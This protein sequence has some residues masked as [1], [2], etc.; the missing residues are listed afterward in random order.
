MMLVLINSFL[1]SAAAVA[2][3]LA[4]SIV[5]RSAV[6]RLVLWY[7]ALIAVLVLSPLTLALP[8]AQG[9][10]AWDAG[11]IV[12]AWLSIAFVSLA[13]IT[14]GYVR[15]RRRL[16]STFVADERVT[17]TALGVRAELRCRR[18]FSTYITAAVRSP[19]F[20]G[21]WRPTIALPASHAR[22]DARELR[23]VLLHEVAHVRRYDDW[24]LAFDA[25]ARS[26]F[27]FNPGVLFIVQRLRFERE[28]SC[29]EAAVSM[30]PASTYTIVLLRIAE[31]TRATLARRID[32][33]RPAHGGASPTANC[34]APPQHR[35]RG[36]D[37]ARLRRIS[38]MRRPAAA[39]S[40]GRESR[41]AGC[42]CCRAAVRG[43]R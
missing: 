5:A 22:M 11:W 29:D 40:R 41:V 37:D 31:K 43:P 24:F 15:A 16:A 32:T 36:S 42:S 6:T 35:C 18:T 12:K 20:L 10:G 21:L 7:A 27:F 4:G 9:A 38:A 17:A 34:V 26:V 14:Y 25:I 1:V 39:A 23:A 3:A 13:A 28:L 19:Q 2:A 30:M 33:P 8:P